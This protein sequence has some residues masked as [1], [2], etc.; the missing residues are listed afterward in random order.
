MFFFWRH[1]AYALAE[2]TSN[3][4]INLFASVNLRIW[5][6]YLILVGVLSLAGVTPSQCLKYQVGL[7]KLAGNRLYVSALKSGMNYPIEYAA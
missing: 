4:S 2:K 7:R 3:Q 1:S 6:S 5:Q